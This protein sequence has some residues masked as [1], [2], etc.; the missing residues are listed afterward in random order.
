MIPLN[1]HKKGT[2]TLV[3]FAGGLIVLAILI[4]VGV[5]ISS[6]YACGLLVKERGDLMREFIDMLLYIS[7]LEDGVVRFDMPSRYNIKITEN[8]IELKLNS[9]LC[10]WLIG[11]EGYTTASKPSSLHILPA[12]LDGR[13][14]CV[15]KKNDIMM[16][17]LE[18]E[19]CCNR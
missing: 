1:M 12:D 16:L 2:S 17:C 4:L 11:D 13:S 7:T 18:G 6:Q 14:F 5:K 10:T 15:K 3:I 8:T 9:R 19:R